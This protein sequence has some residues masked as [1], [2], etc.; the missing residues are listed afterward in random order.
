M[1]HCLDD[2]EYGG[3]SPLTAAFFL[4]SGCLLHVNEKG[5]TRRFG[6]FHVR[7]KIILISDG[8]PTDFT[9]MNN[10][11]IDDSPVFET[12]EDKNH[13]LQYT[14]IIGKFHP[15]FCIPVGR[16][17]DLTLLEFLS[18]QSRGGKIFFPYETRQFA[19]Y[20]ENMRTASML[21]YNMRNDGNDHD[22]IL[23]LLACNFPDKEFSEKD[24]EDIFEICS[25]K[26]LYNSEDSVKAEV[27]D[28]IDEVYQERDPR[29]PPL[30]SRAKRG[31]DWKW[32]NQDSNGPGTVIGHL[33]E[34]GWLNV[35][36]D[37]GL[38]YGYRYGSTK[39]ERDKY[40]VQV[41]NEPRILENEP[42]ATGCPVKR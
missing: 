4:S 22:M 17:P 18:A 15:I 1:K 6:E 31:R 11:N 13:L 32:N 12:E 28:E 30:G 35:N 5:Y 16:K 42:I 41:C 24:Q 37:T 20:T 39:D 21:S 36:W 14:K 8:K 23:T 29:M 10:I 2:V 27:V 7:P 25:K 3:P 38:V 26:S 34:V 33:K 40:D 19:K 9:A